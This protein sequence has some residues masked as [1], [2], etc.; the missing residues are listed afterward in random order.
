MGSADKLTKPGDQT[1][2]RVGRDGI[3][4]VRGEDDKL[5][6]FYNVC[7]HRAHE[8][9]QAG[10]CRNEQAAP[11]PLPRLDLRPRRSAAPRGQEPPADGFDPASEG[12]VPARVEEWRGLIFVNASGD[13]PTLSRVGRRARDD[14][15]SL[16]ARAPEAGCHAR[17]RDRGELEAR[18][19]RTTTSATTARRSTRELCRV[20]PPDSGDNYDK[21]GAFVG[22][23]MDLVPS[24][25]TMS[26]DGHSDGVT[27]RGLSPELL[28]E[29]HYYR[30]VPERPDLSCTRTT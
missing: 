10:E 14:R 9:L 18:R 7:R 11:L 25:V 20:S 4:L 29:V 21:A 15:G 8:L 13:A 27:L 12:L 26:L 23:S 6:A 17:V 2:V 28:R 5:R 30:P 3:L 1:A 22:G 19:A 24:A 16:R